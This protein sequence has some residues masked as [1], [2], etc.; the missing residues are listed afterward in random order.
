MKKLIP[1]AL[2]IL[3]SCGQ[4]ASSASHSSA[5]DQIMASYTVCG[6]SFV[7]SSTQVFLSSNMKAV[8]DGLYKVSNP[9]PCTYE[10]NANEAV[11]IGYPIN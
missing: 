10:I 5:Q 9:A 2:L 3:T 4:T 11:L 8:P 7:A 1:I 6:L